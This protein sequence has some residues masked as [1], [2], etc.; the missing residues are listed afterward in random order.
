MKNKDWNKP[1]LLKN[2]GPH[3]KV[4]LIAF[5]SYHDFLLMFS[6]PIADKWVCIHIGNSSAHIG[7]TH[8]RFPK[9]LWL[10]TMN[11]R[12]IKLTSLIFFLLT[13]TSPTHHQHLLLKEKK[14]CNNFAY[15]N[16]NFYL[17][18]IQGKIFN[19]F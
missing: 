9:Y 6:Y 1:V 15:I 10:L 11:A 13:T 3:I 4:P 8:S 2:N 14:T 17:L 12:H 16:R 5:A 7:Q 19:L 18:E